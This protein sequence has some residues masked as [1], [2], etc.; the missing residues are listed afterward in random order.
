MRLARPGSAPE[1]VRLF[2]SVLFLFPQDDYGV[3]QPQNDEDWLMGDANKADDA[4]VG[5][6]FFGLISPSPVQL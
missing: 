1:S 2:P 6:A 3:Q 4:E 5:P